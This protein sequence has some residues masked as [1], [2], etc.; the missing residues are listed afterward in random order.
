MSGGWYLSACSLEWKDRTRRV[1]HTHRHTLTPTPWHA[2]RTL[3]PT[4]HAPTSS[5]PRTETTHSARCPRSAL[6]AGFPAQ[7]CTFLEELIDGEL[8]HSLYEPLGPAIKTIG[9]FTPRPPSVP[10]GISPFKVLFPRPQPPPAKNA[11]Q[12]TLVTQLHAPHL[13]FETKLAHRR[14]RRSLVFSRALF[15]SISPTPDVSGRL[16]E[17]V[18]CRCLW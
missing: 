7:A 5:R 4:Q 13:T 11:R 12:L 1:L 8:V 15:R 14:I 16:S 3:H 18:G 6:T 2:P 17:R 10:L 9:S